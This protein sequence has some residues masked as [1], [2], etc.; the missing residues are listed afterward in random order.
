MTPVTTTSDQDH[1][2]HWAPT[3]I[4]AGELRGVRPAMR[5]LI[6]SREPTSRHAP[7]CLLLVSFVIQPPPG[8]RCAC[9][10]HASPVHGRCTSDL[11]NPAPN[12]LASQDCC[13]AFALHKPNSMLSLRPGENK[14]AW[15]SPAEREVRKV[16]WDYDLAR[17]SSA[18]LSQITKVEPFKRIMSLS[19]KS[20]RSRV[21]VSREVPIIWAISSWVRVS[22]S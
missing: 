15:Q 9:L 4:L 11:L 21:T 18:A 2:L 5:S 10:G 6:E 22:L 16:V 19:L 20:M 12:L 1:I 8:N 13:Q 3:A 14:A 17:A 7:P